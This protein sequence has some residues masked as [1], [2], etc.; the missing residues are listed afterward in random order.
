[1]ELTYGELDGQWRTR[2]VRTFERWLSAQGGVVQ[3]QRRFTFREPKANAAG[4]AEAREAAR[5][6]RDT[7]LKQTPDGV[8]YFTRQGDGT[9]KVEERPK[10]NGRALAAL[11]LM[12]PGLKPPVFP[13]G[14]FAYF[15]FNAFQRDIQVNALV[16]GVFN[17]ASMAIP[18]L[19]LGLDASVRAS[20]LLIK[21]DERPVKDGKLQ[22]KDAVGHQFGRFGFGLGRD[23]GSGFRLE[24]QAI[25]DYDRY[26]RPRDDAYE[27]PGYVLP[28]S[29][30]TREGRV[31]GSW[32]AHGFQVRAFQGWGHRPEGAFGAPGAVTP[33]P[34]AGR[35]TRWGGGMGQSVELAPRTWLK[36]EAGLEGG[37]GF[38]R[39]NALSVGGG[40]GGG[41]VSGIRSNALDADRIWNAE[42][43][44]AFPTGPNLR[45]TLGLQA[46]R[47]RGLQDQRFYGF[48]GARIAGDLPGF[49]WFTA[50]KVDLG[51]GLQSDIP[52]V[53]TVNGYIA[54]LRVF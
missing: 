29:G 10:S 33:I 32:M 7:M 50:I 54:A 46:A 4:F 30:W 40:F 42:A 22:D 52:G 8:R 15:D 20:A 43:S 6:S 14:G 9:R 18:R 27:T 34:E 3:V 25:L 11:V 36:L 31:T 37:H 16:A 35:F 21:S 53:R 26:G 2:E 38:D 48:T 12:D 49:G 17:T 24:T 39:F 44:L 23:L 13:A 19:P 45:L 28:P 51:V 5:T 47:A 1:M 41:A